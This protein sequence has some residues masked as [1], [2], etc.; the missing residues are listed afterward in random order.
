MPRRYRR[1]SRDGGVGL[2]VLLVIALVLLL[3]VINGKLNLPNVNLRSLPSISIPITGL[4]KIELPK[5][6]VP[7]TLE[8]NKLV[9]PNISING[10]SVPGSA[11]PLSQP[12][13]TSGCRLQGSLPDPA[14]T[15]GAVVNLTHD[16][17]CAADFQGD[18]NGG[19]GAPA[20]QVLKAYAIN[21]A[22]ATQYHID[23]LVPA[24]LGGS[25]DLANL[26]PQ[27]LN[28]PPAYAEK[29]RLEQYLRDQVC[30][31]KISLG[32]AQRQIAL[33][34]LAAYQQMPK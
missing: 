16:Q 21:S 17:V 12:A 20:E 26:W 34:W 18:T 29:N 7:V 30:A 24:V 4:P 6:S 32:D 9:I 33:N 11:N 28:S 19:T 31:G 8:P 27:P 15:P 2:L 3:L 25:N 23:Q 1:N 5:V 14:C 10:T 22:A 13:R